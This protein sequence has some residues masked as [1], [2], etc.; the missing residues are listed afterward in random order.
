MESNRISE[1]E[2]PSTCSIEC[3]TLD[4]NINFDH[5]VKIFSCSPQLHRLIIKDLVSRLIENPIVRC[6]FPQLTSL[7]VEGVDVTID[8]LESFLLL[9]PSLISLKL[10]G[11]CEIFDGKR[12][13]E[14]IQRNL[15]HLNRFQFDIICDKSNDRTREDFEL[16]IES[17]RSPFWIEDRK[18]FIALE[19][20]G[21]R[22]DYLH[23]YSIPMCKSLFFSDF[24]PDKILLSTS[25]EIS[26]YKNISELIFTLERPLIEVVATSQN[27]PYFPNVTKLHLDLAE[28]V[29]INLMDFLGRIIN[30][31]QLIEVKLESYYLNNVNENH[32]YDMLKVLEQCPKL[33]ILSIISDDDDDEIDPFLNKIISILPRQINHLLIPV[34]EMK[35]IEMIFERCPRLTVGQFSTERRLS[36]EITQWC[37]R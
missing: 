2:W 15:P 20:N 32:L 7:I 25:N 18:W 6:S 4:G 35:Q 19:M 29:S 33:S 24:K 26:L 13:E 3:L 17:Y 1:I 16:I 34:K 11:R 37:R 30:L 12:W 27:L 36:R 10:F 14:F 5:L 28:K 22:P 23:I 9:T 21:R 8:Q 31:S